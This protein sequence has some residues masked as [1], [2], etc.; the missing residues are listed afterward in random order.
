VKKILVCLAVLLCSFV[1]YAQTA[2]NTQLVGTVTDPS[3]NVVVGA[4]VTG[5]NVDSKVEYTGTTNNQGYYQ[6]P[7]VLPGTYDVTVE[8]P[9]FS[10]VLVKG[11]IVTINVAVR[12]D[13]QLSVGAAN[14]EVTVSAD[15]PPLSTDDALL[16]ETLSTQQ[17]RDLPMNGRIALNLVAST[18]SNVQITGNALTGNPPGN[19]VV[20]PGTRGV[21]NTVTLDGISVMNNLGSYASIAPN[22]DALDSVQTQS[23]NYTAQYGDYLGY[24]VN[25]VT[26]TGTNKIHGTVYDYIQNDGFNAKSWLQVKTG[27]S[28]VKS[29]LRYNLFGAEVAGPVVIPFLYNGRDKTFFTGSFEGLRNHG[30]GFSQQT[31]LSDRMRAGDFGELCPTGFDGVGHCIGSI[32]AGNAAPSSTAPRQLYYTRGADARTTLCPP[33]P[34]VLP[35]PVTGVYPCA[36]AEVP[37]NNYAVGG[38][39]HAARTIDPVAARVLP[40]LTR[41]N[42]AATQTA[43]NIQNNWSA[44]LPNSTNEDATLDRIDHKIGDKVQLFARFAFQHVTQITSNVNPANNGSSYTKVRNGVVGYTHTFTPNFVSDFRAG[45]QMLYTVNANGT[46]IAGITNGVSSLGIP[47]FNDDPNAPGL[48][49]FTVSGYSGIAQ[50]GSPWPQD[51]RQLTLSEQINYTWGKHTFAAGV[52]FRKLSIGRQAANAARGAFTFDATLN[53]LTSGSGNGGGLFYEGIPKSLTSPI[54]QLKGTVGQWR[55]GFFAQDTWQVTQ[56]FTLQYG[57]RYELPQVAYSI[58]GVARILTPDFLNLYPAVNGTSAANAGSYPGFK[59]Y[60]PQHDNISPRLGFSWRVTDK[61]VVRGGGGIYYNANHLN[62]YTLATTNPPY[63]GQVTPS[64][65]FNQA[66]TF[67]TQVPAIP[68]PQAWPGPAAS[69]YANVTVNY[70]NKTARMYQWNLDV[71]NELW[72]GGGF[73][74]QYLGSH[75]IHLDESNYLNQPGPSASFSTANRPLFPIGQIRNFKNDGIGTYHGLNVILRQRTTHGLTA[76]LSYT[77]SKSMDTSDDSNSS[78]SAMWQNH[79][80]LDYSPSNTDIRNRFTATAS[81]ELPKFSHF[82]YVV[83][84]VL[85]G[86]QTN[87]IFSAQSGSV[88]NPT[89]NGD[90][91]NIGGVGASQRPNYVHAGRTTCSRATVTG[92]GGSQTNSCVDATAYINPLTGTF[93]NVKRNDLR[94]P[95]QINTNASLFKNFALWEGAAFQL[96]GEAF[97]IFNHPNPSN[98]NT[99]FGGPSFGFITSASNSSRTL[100]IAGKINF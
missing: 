82:N 49:D 31:V 13:A 14:T 18:Q 25:Y 4:K 98:P 59:F 22:P 78:G 33:V 15:N 37:Y 83:R 26:R 1:G 74:L 46:Q 16:G 66:P 73:E 94:G 60:G 3:G 56:K 10:R 62:N 9:G 85:G 27:P 88:A 53:G 32:P 91:A 100:Q 51:D 69:P 65:N 89:V 24:H 97:N 99:T 8:Q 95:G 79:L 64:N 50:T 2:N 5:V 76:N 92:P 68:T 19:R 80:K 35:D 81:Y 23:G 36:A 45:F 55:D 87:A 42:Q 40:Y 61:T 58:N 38:F 20:G 7:F 93:G 90:F 41:A 67:T 77:W 6:I 21:N 86:W 28:S 72:K 54:P 12:T 70:N 96:R 63:S 75:T 43:N 44:L 30:S 39:G 11:V 52:N 71:G 48:I 29:Q 47:G 34:G 17:V 57:L 84:E